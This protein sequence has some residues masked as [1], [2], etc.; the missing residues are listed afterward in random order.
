VEKNGHT[1]LTSKIG[2]TVFQT[3]DVDAVGIQDSIWYDWIP[4]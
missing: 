3:L 4:A 2:S 1:I